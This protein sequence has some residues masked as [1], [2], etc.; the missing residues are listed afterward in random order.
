MSKPKTGNGNES[1]FL[2]KDKALTASETAQALIFWIRWLE[3]CEQ[4]I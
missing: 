1:I 4:R 2:L 3:G